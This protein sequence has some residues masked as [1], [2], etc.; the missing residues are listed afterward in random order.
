M[1]LLQLLI[2]FIDFRKDSYVSC[3]DFITRRLQVAIGYEHAVCLLTASKGG[4]LRNSFVYYHSIYS[5]GFIWIIPANIWSLCF[6]RL[7]TQAVTAVFLSQK[8]LPSLSLF[9]YPAS[10]FFFSFLP[11]INCCLYCKGTCRPARRYDPSYSSHCLYCHW[12]GC[13]SNLLQAMFKVIR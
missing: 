10:L 5:S 4:Q 7:L 1:M 12:I 13:S 6:L 8:I 9:F 3:H 2:Y 11:T